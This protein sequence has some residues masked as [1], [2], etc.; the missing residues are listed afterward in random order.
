MVNNRR[1][2]RPGQD[3]TR[4][5]ALGNLDD[6]VTLHAREIRG[7]VADANLREFGINPATALNDPHGP[8]APWFSK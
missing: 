2:Y 5:E 3:E 6:T 8:G 1:R 4:S 7:P